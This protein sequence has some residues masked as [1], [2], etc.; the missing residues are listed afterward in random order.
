[1][2]DRTDQDRDQDRDTSGIAGGRRLPTT[3]TPIEGS[4]DPEGRGTEAADTLMRDVDDD[5]NPETTE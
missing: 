4:S 3:G 1:M 2:L 5:R